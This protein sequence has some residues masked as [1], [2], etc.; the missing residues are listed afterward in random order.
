MFFKKSKNSPCPSASDSV[1]LWAMT[2]DRLFRLDGEC[3]SAVRTK[4]MK[5]ERSH[6]ESISYDH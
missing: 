6:A 4:Q 1:D 5:I 2:F 3:L